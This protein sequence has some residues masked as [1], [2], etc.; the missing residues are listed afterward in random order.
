MVRRAGR[1]KLIHTNDGAEPDGNQA[2]VGAWTL[3]PVEQ[4]LRADVTPDLPFILTCDWL[5]PLSTQQRAAVLALIGGTEARTYRQAA[6]LAGVSVNTLYGYLRRVRRRRP[7]IWEHVIRRRREQVEA[8]QTKNAE[9][10]RRRSE[11]WHLRDFLHDR[12]APDGARATSWRRPA[13]RVNG[14]AVQQGVAVL[15]VV[16]RR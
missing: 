7:D 12:R 10:L 13:G 6:M 9:R 15:A 8:R 3:L 2:G 4:V 16:V 14:R 1:L 11:R 5:D